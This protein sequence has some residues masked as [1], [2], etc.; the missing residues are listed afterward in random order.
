MD[1]LQRRS[2]VR[3]MTAAAFFTS[4]GLS[5][6]ALSQVLENVRVVVGFAPGGTTDAIGRRVA[7]KL[8]D[9]YGRNSIVDNRTGAGGQIA[10]GYM[11]QV[12][13][14]GSTLLVT[15]AG[16]LIVFPHIYS[17]LPYEPFADV[18]PVSL[19][20]VFDHAL[21]VGPAVPASVKT[22]PEFLAWCRANPLQANFGSPGAGTIAHFVGEMLSRAGNANL[23]HAAYRGSQ[24]AIADMLGGQLTAVQSALGDFMP[25][26]KSDR[27]RLLATSG[28][29]RSRFT[30][31]VPTYA[32]Q[33]YKDL[34]INEWFAFFMPA[35]T[36]ADV[37]QRANKALRAALAMPDVVEGLAQM[38][39]EAQSSTP[40]ELG[41]RMKRDYEYWGP[42]V[43]AIGFKADS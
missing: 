33:G 3:G 2:F 9:T 7:D 19:A 5:Q 31:D 34:A 36:P 28:A 14:D 15:P 12:P 23:K 38:G 42:I 35:K 24:P 6:S 43:K 32:E 21:A 18:T 4:L 11:K 17:K 10:V 8:R 13:A 40:E 37:V 1:H 29:K 27:C 26:L 41:A 16:Q 20:S 39:L 22:V 25:H 30:P